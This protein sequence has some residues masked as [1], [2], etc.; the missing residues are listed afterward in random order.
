MLEIRSKTV[1]TNLWRDFSQLLLNKL[2]PLDLPF[3]D[4]IENSSKNGSK[5]S[6]N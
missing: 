6:A 5:K 1:P 3:F 4:F 2:E